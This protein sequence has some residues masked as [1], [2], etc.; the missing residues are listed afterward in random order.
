MLARIVDEA[1]VRVPNAYDT[2]EGGEAE[3]LHAA[4]ESLRGYARQVNAAE[5]GYYERVRQAWQQVTGTSLPD[6]QWRRISADRA[7]WQ[8]VGGYSGTEW[9][10]LT[11]A[12]LAN[13]QSRNGLTLDDL[14]E[15][16]TRGY[17][18]DDWADLADDVLHRAAR[19]SVTQTMRH[20]PAHPRWARVPKGPTCAFCTLLASRGFVY[21]TRESAGYRGGL[22]NSY[23]SHCDCQVAVGWG[24][25]H[26][27]GYDPK[28]MYERYRQCRDTVS[29][30]LTRSRY[31]ADPNAVKADGARMGFDEWELRQVIDEMSKRD[32]RWL[33]DGT[34][35]EIKWA[36]PRETLIRETPRDLEVVEALARDG[37]DVTVLSETAPRNY[38]NIDLK[39]GGQYLEVK[40]PTS[41]NIRNVESNIREAKKQF[42]K[43]WPEPLNEIHVIYNGINVGID[44]GAISAELRKQADKHG[45]DT[46]YQLMKDGRIKKIR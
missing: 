27:D 19:L 10:G 29:G 18:D 21:W 24:D 40:S 6:Y 17:E 34:I 28:G 38:R 45:I 39:I 14:W 22:Y 36:K 41:R 8:S 30:M 44:D 9:N 32:K 35:P 12:Q 43:H 26:I 25:T 31:A 11:F 5:E 42:E 33:Y 37:F 7:L 13:G 20:D 23:H 4:Q 1:R 15:R 46:V 16:S 3:R 2:A